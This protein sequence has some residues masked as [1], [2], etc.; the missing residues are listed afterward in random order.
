M[1]SVPKLTQIANSIKLSKDL[2]KEKIQISWPLAHQSGKGFAIGDY[3]DSLNIALT[4][5]GYEVLAEIE[6]V[7]VGTNWLSSIVVA[8]RFFGPWAIDI[9]DYLVKG[10]YATFR[11]LTLFKPFV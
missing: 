9:T 1:Q 7:S 5:E 8:T 11:K 4:K 6:G 10:D 2:W 3:D